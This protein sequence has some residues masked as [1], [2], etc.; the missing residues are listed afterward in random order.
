LRT[1]IRL[2]AGRS[3]KRFVEAIRTDIP[4]KFRNRLRTRYTEKDGRRSG[5]AGKGAEAAAIAAHA[6][7]HGKEEKNTSHGSERSKDGV[8]EP[9]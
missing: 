1:Q 2:S 8:V 5:Y 3:A 6:I 7:D 9:R 4:T